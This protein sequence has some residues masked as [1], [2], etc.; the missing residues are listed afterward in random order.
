MVCSA[1]YTGSRSHLWHAGGEHSDNERHRRAHVTEREKGERS[2]RG[3]AEQAESEAVLSSKDAMEAWLVTRRKLSVC[4]WRR[5]GACG[6]GGQTH[7]V[8]EGG[9]IGMKM[10]SHL[11]GKR[12]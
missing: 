4:V 12:S 3:D 7:A 9:R 6:G 11:R 1:M 5:A 8:I 2:E 10:C